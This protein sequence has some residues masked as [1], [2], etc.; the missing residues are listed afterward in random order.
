MGVAIGGFVIV[1]SV[2]AVNDGQIMINESIPELYIR[3]INPGYK[4]PTHRFRSLEQQ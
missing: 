2:S 4:V 1:R 3:A